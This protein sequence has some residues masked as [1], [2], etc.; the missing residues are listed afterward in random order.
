MGQIRTTVLRLFQPLFGG[1]PSGAPITVL[2]DDSVTQVANIFPDVARRSLA[3]PESGWFTCTMQNVHSGA[4]DENNTINPY[5]VDR[6]L[7]PTTS[8]YPSPVPAEQELWICGVT[9]LATGDGALAGAHLGIDPVAQQQGWGRDDAGA[10]VAG[11][12]VIPIVR[13]D[14]IN[15]ATIIDI[16]VMGDGST[17]WRGA[18]RIPRR[19]NLNFR[20]TSGAANTFNC[21]IILG[22][23][24][25]GLGQD[26]AAG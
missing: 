5:E 20:S 7:I 11:V 26:I 14:S 9:L 4:D 12:G 13:W 15:S 25:T 8:S 6:I 23:F 3:G 24:P 10:F 1:A 16:G 18:V 2:E 17:H 22:L 21:V 19:A